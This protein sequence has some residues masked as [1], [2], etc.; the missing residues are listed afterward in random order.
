MVRQVQVRLPPYSHKLVGHDFRLGD[1][2]RVNAQFSAQYCVANAVVRGAS[3]L[4]HFRAEQVADPAV[5]ALVQRV[6]TQAVPAMDARGH[7]AVDIVLTT[8]D[9]Q[10]HERSL[11]IAPGYPGCE[12]SDAQQRTRFDDCLAYAARPLPAAQVQTFLA[13][14]HTLADLNDARTLLDVLVLPRDKSTG[15][16]S[17]DV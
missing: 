15:R 13:G 4:P 17:A 11:D 16:E 7:T 3:K 8:V 2:P 5:L 6:Y 9:G 10:V 1:N 14:L 12:L